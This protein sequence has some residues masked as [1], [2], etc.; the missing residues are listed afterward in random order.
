LPGSHT[1]QKLATG[2]HPDTATS[3]EGGIDLE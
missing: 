2:F 1:E 3:R